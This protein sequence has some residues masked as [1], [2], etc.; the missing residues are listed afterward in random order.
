[1]I[2]P[3][4][5]IATVIALIVLAGCAT[6]TSPDAMNDA[7]K[8]LKAMDSAWSVATHTVARAYVAGKITTEQ[9]DR[10]RDLDRKVRMTGRLLVEAQKA[11][12]TG[13]TKDGTRIALLTTNLV[14]LMVEGAKLAAEFGLN[15]QDLVKLADE[16]KKA[17]IQ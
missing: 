8:A 12:E 15:I 13:V 2:R 7:K 4:R 9:S 16:A 3:S 10:F 17:G 6:A 11:W 5:L 14:S 1:M